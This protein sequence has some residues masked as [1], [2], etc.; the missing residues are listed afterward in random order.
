MKEL[1]HAPGRADLTRDCLSVKGLRLPPVTYFD[2]GNRENI[3][4][5]FRKP[6]ERVFGALNRV[7]DVK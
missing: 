2:N 5:E 1:K 4:R 3:V 6:S 7:F